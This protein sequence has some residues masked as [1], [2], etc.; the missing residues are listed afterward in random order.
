MHYIDHDKTPF[1]EYNLIKCVISSSKV[2]RFFFS[3]SSFIFIQAFSYLSNSKFKTSNQKYPRVETADQY[4][5][6]LWI[7]FH[8]NTKP[9]PDSSHRIDHAINFPQKDGSLKLSCKSC[10]RNT[11]IQEY[12]EYE[13]LPMLTI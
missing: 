7:G 11:S 13:Y 8:G 12:A 10:N 1:L 5:K 3:S 9:R 6:S 2:P 4:T